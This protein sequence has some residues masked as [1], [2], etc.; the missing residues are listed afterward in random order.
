[1]SK[2]QMTDAQIMK[3]RA[4]AYGPVKEQMATIGVIQME[5]SRYCLERN[6]GQPSR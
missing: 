3:G 5:L 1:M 6:N 4:L 2:K